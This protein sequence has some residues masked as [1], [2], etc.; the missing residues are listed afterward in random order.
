M[1]VRM[2][3][4]LGSVDAATKGIHHADYLAGAELDVSGELGN[5]LVAN[6]HAEEVAK[7]IRGEAKASAVQGVPPAKTKSKAK[8]AE[9]SK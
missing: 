1:I 5:W 8:D 6:G 9:A 3:V 2:R 4:N 7:E